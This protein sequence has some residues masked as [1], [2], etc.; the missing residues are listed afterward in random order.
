MQ[1]TKQICDFALHKF[2]EKIEEAILD[3]FRV[4]KTP[5]SYA[6]LIGGRYST[7]MVKHKDVEN[8]D[9]DTLGDAVKPME[10]DPVEI[11]DNGTPEPD[12]VVEPVVKPTTRGRK[13][14]GDN[15]DS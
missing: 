13:K 1:S 4:H 11:L 2:L 14:A 5:T 8:P 12:V 10:A 3:G 6:K 7:V 15:D 9:C